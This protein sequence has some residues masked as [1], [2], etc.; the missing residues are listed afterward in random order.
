[1]A[2]LDAAW[3]ALGSAARAEA[4]EFAAAMRE[5]GEAQ[6][7]LLADILTHNRDSPFGVAHGFAECADLDEFRR[8][9]PI[10]TDADFAEAIAA[11]AADGR[12]RLTSEPPVAFE[13]TGGS[14][15]GAKL[16]PYNAALLASFRSATLVWLDGVLTRCPQVLRGRFYATISPATRA[17]EVTGAGIPIGLASDAA[18]LGDDLAGHFLALLAVPPELGLI[19]DPQEWR[20]ATLAALIE[21]EDLT[22]VSLWSP[23]FLLA[24]IDALPALAGPVAARLARPARARLDAA[25]AGDA[26][27][28]ARLWPML[29]CIS[30]WTDG[31][32]AAFAAALAARFPHAVID[33]KGVLATE[34]PITLSYGEKAICIPAL[35]Q[36]V[37]EFVDAAGTPH[38]CDALEPGATYR[39]VITTTGGLYRY[40]I[41]DLFQCR[42]V[43]GGVPELAFVGRAGLTCDLVGEKLEDG[44]V[45]RAL[46]GLPAVLAPRGDGCGYELLVD[47]AHAAAIDLAAIDH[48]LAANPQYAYARK[49]G[50]LEPL[51]TRRIADLSGTLIAHGIAAGRVMGDIKTSGLLPAPLAEGS[52]R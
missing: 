14:G 3:N 33:P 17:P 23:T 7:A 15:G 41:G 13:R 36:C 44:F 51:V 24:L 35:T 25:L 16:V 38:L 40:D 6:R 34:A 18:Y 52:R 10:R 8:G 11:T 49:I 39:A 27:D 47:A 50:Q 19:A 31:A 32:S 4:Q 1:M 46:A 9:V 48:A 2:P 37:T 43:H 20:I 21:A 5:P 29:A 30:C 12:P 45:A 26:L 28:T 42:A 22:F